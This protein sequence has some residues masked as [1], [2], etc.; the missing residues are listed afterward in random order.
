M[1][2]IINCISSNEQIIHFC[3]NLQDGSLDSLFG[4][5]Y[6]G[7]QIV[8]SLKSFLIK[9]SAFNFKICSM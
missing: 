4:L 5:A 6:L 2:T 9:C 1:C 3:S 8:K 7:K